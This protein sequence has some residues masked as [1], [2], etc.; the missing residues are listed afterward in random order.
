MYSWD[1]QRGKPVLTGP[2]C[3]SS[4]LEPPTA[5]QQPSDCLTL[6]FPTETLQTAVYRS[7]TSH[8]GAQQY[9]NLKTASLK[10]QTNFTL[11]PPALSQSLKMDFCTFLIYCSIDD[12]DKRGRTNP[13]SWTTGLGV[14][15]IT[16]WK[17]AHVSFYLKGCRFF[18]LL[19]PRDHKYF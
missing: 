7:A 5:F 13:R 4:L 9:C 12:N 6:R 18:F 11:L 3:P 10:T 17:K 2:I 8:V 16:E 19:L 1:E 14:M 15:A